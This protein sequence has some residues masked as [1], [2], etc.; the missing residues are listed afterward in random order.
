MG[1]QLCSEQSWEGVGHLQAEE[2]G[3]TLSVWPDQEG[4][5]ESQLGLDCSRHRGRGCLVL[6]VTFTIVERQQAV[7]GGK[8][9]QAWAVTGGGDTLSLGCDRR[10]A[11]SYMGCDGEGTLR[12]GL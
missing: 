3:G 11:Q 10:M 8:D 4:G 9:S 7:T 6:Q 2:L 12:P 5:P 1:N